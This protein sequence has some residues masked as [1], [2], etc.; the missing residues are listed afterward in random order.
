MI[1]PTIDS[2]HP[3]GGTQHLR[4]TFDTTTRTNIPGFGLGVDARF[5]INAHVTAFPS[6]PN[7][8]SCDMS[9]DTPFGQDYRVQPQSI[10]QGSLSTSAL[11]F[12][13]SGAIYILD[14]LCGSTGLAFQPTGVSWDTTG[15][16][17]NYTVA[18]NPCASPDTSVYTYGGAPLF[19]SCVPAGDRMEQFLIFGD[20]YPGSTADVDNVVMTGGDGCPSECGNGIIETPNEQCEPGNVP[21][22]MQS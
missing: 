22:G 7:T 18:L 9:I 13:D 8:M 10:S 3:A 17:Q 14:D 6:A 15:G 16:Y 11:F 4:S 12:S 1:T 2:V 20:N 5:P 19:A 21:H